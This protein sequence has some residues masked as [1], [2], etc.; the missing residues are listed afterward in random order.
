M[1]VYF[2]SMLFFPLKMWDKRHIIFFSTPRK[3]RMSADRLNIDTTVFGEKKILVNNTR[4]Q[5][6]TCSGAKEPPI[7]GTGGKACY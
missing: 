4:L 2:N 3:G 1:S 7:V 5:T 6:Y